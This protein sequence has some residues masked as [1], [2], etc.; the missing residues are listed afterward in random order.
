MI[1]IIKIVEYFKMLTEIVFIGYLL[2]LLPM[3]NL[4][5]ELILLTSQLYAIY[6]LQCLNILSNVNQQI[7]SIKQDV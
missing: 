2:L 7:F 6:I 3:S 5:N 1:V 4:V